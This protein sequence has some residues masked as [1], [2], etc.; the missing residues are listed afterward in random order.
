MTERLT[1]LNRKIVEAQDL[2]DFLTRYQMPISF[3]GYNYL[4]NELRSLRLEFAE[5]ENKERK[6]NHRMITCN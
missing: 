5:L 2:L 6:N 4:F 1:E 3:G